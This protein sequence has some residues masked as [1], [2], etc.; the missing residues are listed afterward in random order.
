[1]RQLLRTA[2]AG[3]R[4]LRVGPTR[5]TMGREVVVWTGVVT[6]ATSA[7]EEPVTVVTLLHAT[8]VRPNGP[9]GIVVEG[10]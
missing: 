9:I 6:S 8:V 10:M 3:S 1:M 7:G 2:A 4:V 5:G